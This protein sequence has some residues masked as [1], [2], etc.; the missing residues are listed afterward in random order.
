VLQFATWLIDFIGLSLALWLAAY[1][2][3]RGIR[4]AVTRWAG[5][6]LA[7]IAVAFLLSLYGLEAP[8]ANL[9]GWWALF[10]TLALLAWYTLTYQFL[11]PSMRYRVR[12]MA[13]LIYVVGLL[14][15]FI[16][17]VASAQGRVSTADSFNI[18]PYDPGL[19]GLVDIIFL[20]TAAGGTLFNFRLGSRTGYGPHFPPLWIA[21]VFGAIAIAY[22]SVAIF[23]GP[24]LPRA[25]QE[26]C[27]VI[28]IALSGYAIARYQAFVERRTTLRDMPVSG[29][30]VFGLAALYGW[31]GSRQGFSPAGVALIMALAVVTHVT[32]D[33]VREVLDRLLHRNESL[34]RQ[35]LRALA[36]D[37][38]S[39]AD[40]PA[41][42]GAGLENLVRLLDATGGFIAV[43]RE[44]GF[45]VSASVASLPEGT[46]I[47]AAEAEFA[48]VSPPGP[49]L[50]DRIAWLA[51]A[52][53]GEQQVAVVGL[54]HRANRGRYGEADVDL[55]VDMADWVGR[56][57]EG[58]TRQRARREELLKAADAVKSGDEELKAQAQNLLT[59]FGAQPDRNFA[60]QVEHALQHL[61]D[62][63]ALGQSA[64]VDELKLPGVTHIER[65]KALRQC[66][67]D[68]IESL[69]P[70]E[71]RPRSV[72]PREWRAYAVLYDAYVEDVPNREI[73]ARLYIGEGNFNRT[74]RAALQAVARAVYETR[75][76]APDDMP[77]PG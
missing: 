29:L 63:T 39:E 37:A 23:V 67:L 19:A 57:V 43:R 13:R 11:T 36:R 47:D 50:M 17:G 5:L 41:H 28:A 66:L 25:I 74:R 55:M 44:A 70:A 9:D 26:A 12:W 24:I 46:L 34:F 18:N 27:L 62:F 32:Y 22:G 10:Q 8:Q 3:S 68:A 64:L 1:L 30:V 54:A 16:L 31:L 4:S 72:L 75:Y 33:V 69:R 73:M 77:V 71:A 15:V 52:F 49:A 6:T 65:G 2:V 59:A 21:S 48:D 40:L 42:L 58:E 76:H 51:P 38:G 56:V 35:Q 61:S 60:R 53:G 20:L 45:V 7:F 14:K